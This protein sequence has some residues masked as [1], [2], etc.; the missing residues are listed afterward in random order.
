MCAAAKELNVAVR[1]TSIYRETKHEYK[2]DTFIS[3]ICLLGK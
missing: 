3:C 1:Y 2:M